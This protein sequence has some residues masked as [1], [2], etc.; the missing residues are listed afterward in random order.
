[1]NNFV[2]DNSG[3]QIHVREDV[4]PYVVYTTGDAELKDFL[5][6]SAKQPI[7]KVIHHQVQRKSLI[8]DMI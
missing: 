6:S 3:S 8:L 5:L 4:I 7:Q 2:Q 1:V